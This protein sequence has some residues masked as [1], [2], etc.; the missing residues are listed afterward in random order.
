[1]RIEQLNNLPIWRKISEGDIHLVTRKD[2]QHLFNVMD[3]GKKGYVS[4][5]A[6]RMQLLALDMLMLANGAALS[7]FGAVKRQDIMTLQAVDAANLTENDLQA[8]LVPESFSRQELVKDV[9]KDGNSKC[10]AARHGFHAR[11]IGEISL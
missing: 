3:D 7:C 4:G 2:V 9:D 6:T 5:A 11:Y 8:M 10:S 1:M